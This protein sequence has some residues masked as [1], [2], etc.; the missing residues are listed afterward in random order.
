MANLRD[1]KRRIKSVQST[2]QITNAMKMVA[3][4]KLRRV[5]NAFMA[6]IP[7]EKRLNEVITH[8]VETGVS[9]PLMEQRELK[10]EYLV[11][12]GGEQGLCGGYNHNLNRFTEHYLQE[13]SHQTSLSVVGNRTSAYLEKKGWKADLT[14]PFYLDTSE[15]AMGKL[16]G[17]QLIKEYLAR[18]TDKVTL[19][20]TEF[21]SA[22][23]Q[24]VTKWQL[25]PISFGEQ[26]LHVATAF[27]DSG[28]P[29]HHDIDFSKYLFEPD[30]GTLLETILP[31]YVELVIYS[32]LLQ[33]RAS[34][35][36]A[37]M[38]AMT[39]ASDNADE[40]IDELTLVS[41]RVRQSIIT[42]ELT[43]IISGATALT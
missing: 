25:L 3:A 7:Y 20:F 30:C 10:K 39:A 17:E 21:K 5:Q 13:L 11:V 9:H 34:E 8:I 31:Q 28:Q 41:N 38:T 32:A 37:R 23:Q 26:R 29:D 43:E 36:R 35:F 40:L 16:V 33:S 14:L 6:F 2:Q 42:T 4:A 12:F 15:Y 24:T 1:I 22:M 19:I 18:T 27:G